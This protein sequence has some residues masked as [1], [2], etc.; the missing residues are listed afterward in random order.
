M[1]TPIYAFFILYAL[2]SYNFWMMEMASVLETCSYKHVKHATLIKKIYRELK[3]KKYFHG[4]AVEGIAF[5]QSEELFHYS[6][7]VSAVSQ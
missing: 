3:K 4:V 5:Q 2:V 7:S 1:Y 6:M